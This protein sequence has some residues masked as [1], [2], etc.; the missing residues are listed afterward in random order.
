MHPSLGLSLSAKTSRQA[1][2]AHYC[3]GLYLVEG[4]DAQ[5][6]GSVLEQ[7]TANDSG[8][9]VYLAEDSAASFVDTTI[10]DNASR[11]GGGIELFSGVAE[12]SGVTFRGNDPDDLYVHRGGLRGVILSGTS[13][14]PAPPGP[15]G[16]A[17]AAPT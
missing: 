1:W 3:G 11:L 4:S 16:P 2:V 12:G 6:T 14:P 15:P 17:A 5:V 10:A 8:G 13:G 9:A 7:N